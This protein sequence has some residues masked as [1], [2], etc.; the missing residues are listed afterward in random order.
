M[1]S[2]V[3]KTMFH[4]EW[5]KYVSKCVSKNGLVALSNMH[6]LTQVKHCEEILKS[7]KIVRHSK[8]LLDAFIQ[9]LSTKIYKVCSISRIKRHQK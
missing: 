1:A 6:N 2:L 3:K 4:T 5:K 7:H 9:K 8:N